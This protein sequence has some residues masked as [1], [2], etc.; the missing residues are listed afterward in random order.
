MNL[1]SALREFR[2]VHRL[3]QKQLAAD[4]GISLKHYSRIEEGKDL[5][6]VSLLRRICDVTGITAEYY[7]SHDEWSSSLSS[8]ERILLTRFPRASDRIRS[9]VLELLTLENKEQ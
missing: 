9:L 2:K 1:Q 7:L 6:S 4:L 3:L 8:E 5:P